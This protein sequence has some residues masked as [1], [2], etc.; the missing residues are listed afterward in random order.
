MPEL[1]GRVVMVRWCVN[2]FLED[3]V[4]LL[5]ESSKAKSQRCFLLPKQWKHRHKSSVGLVG[6]AGSSG[7][8][9]GIE[10]SNAWS[11]LVDNIRQFL[12][13]INSIFW[14]LVKLEHCGIFKR[15]SKLFH[16]V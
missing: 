16:L 7:R 2:G 9:P 3:K 8:H 1:N 11:H 4:G 15:S 6:A 12:S 13:M 5:R 10:I 14:G